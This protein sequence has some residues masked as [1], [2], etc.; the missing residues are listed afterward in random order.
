MTQENST[1]ESTS[2]EAPKWLTP[3]VQGIGVASFLSDLGHEVP[4]SLF[5]SLLINMLG[6]SA[7]ALGL[8][9]G[10]ADGLAGLA[11]LLGGSLADD[12]DRRRRTAIGGYTSTAILSAL[13]GAA[14]A[15]WQVAV[16]R[17]AAWASRRLRVLA[18]NALLADMV[19][20]SVY[21]RA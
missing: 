14:G 15:V 4:T 11:R 3:G 8:V 9:E 10:L 1:S 7:A 21:G 18:R 5:P 6:A 17:M 19:P 2:D 20:T 12:P 13:I 16:L